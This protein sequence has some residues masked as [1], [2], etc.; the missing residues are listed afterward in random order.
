MAHAIP[1]TTL[2]SWAF[3]Y[4]QANQLLTDS[5]D[6]YGYDALGRLVQAEMRDP[7]DAASGHGLQQMMQYDAFGNRVSLSSQRVTNWTTSTSLPT[8]PALTALAAGDTRVQSYAMTSGEMASMAATNRLP[9]TIGGVAT[10]AA[11][12]AQGNLTSIWTVPGSSGTQLTMT[13][14]SLGRVATLGD[15][16]NATS[17]TYGYDDEGLRIKVTDSKT[18]L[19]SYNVYD[20]GRRLIAQ[21]TIP[22]AGSLT[23]KKDIVYV[24][25]KEVAELDA[26]GKTWV[27]F[28]DHLGSPRYEWDGTSTT[29]IDGVHLITQKYAPFGEYLNN[30]T[31]PAKFAKGFTNHE[32]T[33]A[34]GLVYMQ[35]R[36]YAPMYGRFLSPDPA[37]DQHFEETQSWNIYSYVQNSPTMR[38]D[39]T[40]MVGTDSDDKAKENRK[41]Q[42]EEERKKKQEEQRKKREEA[43]KQRIEKWQAMHKKLSDEHISNIIFNELRSLDGTEIDKALRDIANATINGDK[44]SFDE[45]HPRPDTASTDAKVPEVEAERY[46]DSKRAAQVARDDQK[47]GTDPTNGATHFNLRNGNSKK[48]FQGHKLKTQRG[49]F[50]NSFPT[51]TLKGKNIYVN[52][53]E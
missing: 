24:G 14:D 12:D 5:E 34:S 1:W 43:R 35:A 33:D 29:T 22:S 39:P 26:A 51:P 30:T 31:T 21:Y 23:W 41:K 6:A 47:H 17:Q 28:L 2:A 7:L 13:Y 18:G 32:Q 25:D 49:P 27:Q 3:T 45:G 20:E 37:R 42:Q 40:G 38:I 52:T 15:T 9:A 53:Y 4:D 19:V 8:A 16:A 48:P 10:G 44:E 50:T 46:E 36:F 11:Y